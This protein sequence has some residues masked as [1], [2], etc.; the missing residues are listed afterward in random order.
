[1][2][3]LLLPPILFLILILSP[4]TSIQTANNPPQRL[5]SIMSRPKDQERKETHK[6]P[7]EFRKHGQISMMVILAILVEF[8]GCGYDV[9]VVVVVAIVAVVVGLGFYERLEDGHDDNY[10]DG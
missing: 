8:G 5:K 7:T 2:S 1:M 9:V 6:T 10:S 3:A 4:T